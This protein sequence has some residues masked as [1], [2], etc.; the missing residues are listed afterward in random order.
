MTKKNYI[1]P[2]STILE[3]KSGALL[4][5]SGGKPDPKDDGMEILSKPSVW[6]EA[7][8]EEDNRNSIEF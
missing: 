3:I 4:D 8:L 2:E 1:Q 7:E 5:V 6:D